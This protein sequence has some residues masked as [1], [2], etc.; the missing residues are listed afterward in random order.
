M[1]NYQRVSVRVLHQP[2]ALKF[3]ENVQ[4]FHRSKWIKGS[5]ECFTIP[6]SP[7]NPTGG[8]SSAAQDSIG[9][10]N[11]VAPPFCFRHGASSA[12]PE[13]IQWELGSR[14]AIGQK[15]WAARPW[16]DL[17][18]GPAVAQKKWVL[19]HIVAKCQYHIVTYVFFIYIYIY[20]LPFYLIYSP[21]NGSGYQNS[22]PVQVQQN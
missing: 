12:L 3:L 10:P 9:Q 16:E 1:L 19:I 6:E 7:S 18:S 22:D 20:H 13:T 14:K 21:L 8:P 4:N 11:V 15:R 17:E 5:L 2:T